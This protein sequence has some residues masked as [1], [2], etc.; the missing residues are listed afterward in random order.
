MRKLRPH[1][2]LLLKQAVEATKSSVLLP[3]SVEIT[4]SCVFYEFPTC[5]LITV[6]HIA[7]GCYKP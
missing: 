5:F 1:T 7:L 6:S 4:G 2:L 3:F